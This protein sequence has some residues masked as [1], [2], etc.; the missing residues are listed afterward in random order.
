MRKPDFYTDF[1]KAVMIAVFVLAFHI[2]LL[3]SIGCDGGWSV[4]GLDL[5]EKL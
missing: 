3:V 1:F 5:P 4:G 2:V